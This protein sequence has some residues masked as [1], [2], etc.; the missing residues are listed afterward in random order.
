MAQGFTDTGG[1]KA[2]WEL[3]TKLGPDADYVT[4]GK[5]AADVSGLMGAFINYGI[6]IAMT[7]ALGPVGLAQTVA[8]GA[9]GGGLSQALQ[10]ASIGDIAKTAGISGLTA[11]AMQASGATDALRGALGGAGSSP[12][13]SDAFNA[14][15]GAGGA[16]TGGLSGAGLGGIGNA[17]GSLADEILVTAA[18]QA[19]SAALPVSAAITGIAGPALA[20]ASRQIAA[21]QA[22]P[23][24]VAEAS[25]IPPA[26]PP[27]A[28]IPAVA[29][30]PAIAGIGGSPTTVEPEIVAEASRIPP[31]EFQGPLPIPAASLNPVEIPTINPA[32]TPAIKKPLTLQD[33]IR[34]G[35]GASSLAQGIGGLLGIGNDG[36]VGAGIGG[37]NPNMGTVSYQP[38]NRVR[39][40]PTF[41]PFTYGQAGGN[42]PAEFRFFQPS[43]PNF[44]INQPAQVGIVPNN[45]SPILGV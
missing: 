16:L 23:E 6:P 18:R 44:Q 32:E 15:R 37:F 42:Q 28:V 30:I 1:N 45:Q 29:A 19:P 24:I 21:E 10:G 36:N 33:Y 31:S 7:A 43:A 4:V 39:N 13:L 22:A 25:R 40:A 35:L 12:Q 2:D 8:A 27:A 11:G 17:A 20:E 34:Y 9:V 3:K 14:A 38:L 5:D 26:I 41:D